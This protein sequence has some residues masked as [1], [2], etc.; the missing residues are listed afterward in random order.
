MTTLRSDVGNAAHRL[1]RAGVSSSG[2]VSFPEGRRC[3]WRVI[4]AGLR[5]VIT[6]PLFIVIPPAVSAA[7]PGSSPS[8]RPALPK[9]STMVMR[10]SSLP[11]KRQQNRAPRSELAEAI[12]AAQ[13]PQNCPDWP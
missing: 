9:P 3:S 8:G 1:T 4:A 10:P 13:R 12:Q 6:Y 11:D 5:N 2:I 7:F